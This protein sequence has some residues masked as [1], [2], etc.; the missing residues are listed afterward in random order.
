MNIQMQ[1]AAGVM[2]PQGTPQ[3]PPTM[4]Q[5]QQMS[6]PPDKLDNI[7]KIKSLVGPLR[8]TLAIT[9]KS[10][11][12]AIHQNSLIDVGSSKGVDIPTIRFDKHTEEFYSICDQIEL[13][14]KTSIECMNQ[15]SSSQRYLPSAVVPTRTEPLPGQDQATLTYPQ[16]LGTVRSQVA[17]A[18]E[19]HDTLVAAA[20]NITPSE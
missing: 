8:D 11:S 19:V 4:Q 12:Q 3:Q 14:L 7:S 5:S 13:H 20:Q 9:L 2:P 18:K 17:Y 15:G 6:Q 10:A 16:Y 1:Q